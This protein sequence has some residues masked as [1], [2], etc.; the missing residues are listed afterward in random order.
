MRLLRDFFGLAWRIPRYSSW[1]FY[2]LRCANFHELIR[3]ERSG[4][5]FDCIYL[6]GGKVI[7]FGDPDHALMMFKDIWLR[8]IYDRF[9]HRVPRVVVDIGANIGVFSLYAKTLWPSCRIYAYEPDHKNFALLRRNV[10]I[11][12]IAHDVSVFNLAVSKQQGTA[13]LFLKSRSGWHSLFDIQ[14]DTGRGEIEVHTTSLED[15]ISS[16]TDYIDFLKIDCEGC[17]WPSLED[18]ASSLRESVGYVAM[19]YHEMSGKSHLDLTALFQRAGFDV[20]VGPPNRW[21]T[22]MLYAV[23]RNAHRSR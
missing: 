3:Y 6:R 2:L 21:N 19:E 18:K 8:N 16:N 12:Q 7:Y 11:S 15:I 20:Q 22:G 4:E 17:E 5:P 1:I 9:Y 23:N 14:G 13:T 10:E